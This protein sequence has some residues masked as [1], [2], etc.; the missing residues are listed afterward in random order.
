VPGAT[1]AGEGK[2][3]FLLGRVTDGPAAEKSAQRATVFRDKLGFDDDSLSAAL[4]QQL[5]DNFAT[6]TIGP[7]THPSNV[8][9]ITV[10]G[11]I[12]GP[13]GV[14]ETITSGW[15]IRPDGSVTLNTAF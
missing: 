15:S 7:S 10:K 3:G 11:S 8:G 9:T 4:E 6:G 1:N 14:T 2:T 5:K 13:N 12:T